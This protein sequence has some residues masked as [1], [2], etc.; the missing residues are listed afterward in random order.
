[1]VVSGVRDVCGGVRVLGTVA[2]VHLSLGVAGE[3]DAAALAR[4]SEQSEPETLR[5]LQARDLRQVRQGPA[6]HD[7]STKE[8][9]QIDL[10]TACISC[11]T[12]LIILF[13]IK[14]SKEVSFC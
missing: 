7:V 1:L 6:E 9:N 4:A 5:R 14:Y 2:D 3:E 12:Q 11:N 8:L 13:T 10:C